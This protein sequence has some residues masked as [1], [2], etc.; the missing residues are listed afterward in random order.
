PIRPLSA[1]SSMLATPFVLI[2]DAAL[3]PLRAPL[4]QSAASRT[5]LFGTV[6]V[7]SLP[8]GGPSMRGQRGGHWP[9]HR[10]KVKAQAGQGWQHAQ[11]RATIEPML[12]RR[13]PA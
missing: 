10:A 4:D 8:L 3:P 1:C 6:N 7:A 11:V 12:M 9:P 13:M 2:P 5:G